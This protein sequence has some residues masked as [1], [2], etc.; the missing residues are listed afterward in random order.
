MRMNR[1]LDDFL[2]RNLSFDHRH[3]VSNMDSHI[4]NPSMILNVDNHCSRYIQSICIQ[5]LDLHVNSTGICRRHDV[6]SPYIE[7]SNRKRLVN[8]M[9]F[10]ILN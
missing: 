1:F 3:L 8:C 5:R 2:R 7:R 9:D 4:S 10:Y 6:R